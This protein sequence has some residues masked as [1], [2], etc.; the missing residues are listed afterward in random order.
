[1]PHATLRIEHLATGGFGAVYMHRMVFD[2]AL[3]ATTSCCFVV[4]QMLL[5]GEEDEV[6]FEQEAALLGHVHSHP[7]II[8]LL[9]SC[10][11]T[12]LGQQH[13]AIYMEYAAGGDLL[14]LLL[15]KGPM[16]Q[17]ERAPHTTPSRLTNRRC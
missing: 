8:G 12:W 5:Q 4:K 11:S 14:T 13:G 1:M 16:S 6:R 15:D 9:G 17:G 7:A 3:Q 10:R 2:G